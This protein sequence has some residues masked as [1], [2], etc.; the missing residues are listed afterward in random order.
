MEN[1]V[2]FTLIGSFTSP[3]VR[4]LRLL[5]LAKEIRFELQAINYLT[6][7]DSKFLKSTNPINKI[8]VL[9]VKEKDKKTTTVYDSRVI[10]QFLTKKFG[11]VPLSLEEENTLSFIDGM[12]DTAINLFSLQRAGL[13]TKAGNNSYIERQWERID[14]ILKNMKPWVCDQSPDRD[15]NFLNMSLYSFLD[16]AQF[17]TVISLTEYPEYADYLN[18]FKLC[19]G[20]AETEIPKT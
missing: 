10:F 8:P 6:P 18:R 4:K 2:D 1:N 9:L 17:R 15:W 19:K 11:W 5:F 7:D 3:Y 13:D 14:L 16:W 12:L 20:V